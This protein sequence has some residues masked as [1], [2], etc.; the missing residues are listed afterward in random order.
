MSEPDYCGCCGRQNLTASDY[1][2]QDCAAH[3]DPRWQLQPHD[4]TW[5]AQ[6]GTACP[7]EDHD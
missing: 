3:V 6:H 5:F 7:N 2:C 4:R 1:W